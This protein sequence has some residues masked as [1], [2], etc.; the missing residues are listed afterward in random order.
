VSHTF[1]VSYSEFSYFCFIDGGENNGHDNY[2]SG[3]GT[4]ILI[5]IYPTTVIETVG[6]YSTMVA[7]AVCLRH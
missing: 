4:I 2:N 7:N 5:L 6:L 1:L 3:D